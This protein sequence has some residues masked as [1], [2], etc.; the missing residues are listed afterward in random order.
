[1]NLMFVL[2]FCETK[3]VLLKKYYVYKATYA[4]KGEKWDENNILNIL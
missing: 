3:R 2:F 1:M 4:I